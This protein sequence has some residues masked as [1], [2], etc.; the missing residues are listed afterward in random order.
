VTAEKW[1]SYPSYASQDYFRSSMEGHARVREVAKRSPTRWDLT[2][3]NDAVVRAFITDVY[4]FSV[5]DYALLRAAHP[6]VDIIVSASKW[7]HF[8]SEAVEA[9]EEDRVATVKLGG[10][11]MSVLHDFANGRATQG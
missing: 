6:E 1:D 2:L 9:A 8:S 7:N 11:L 10:E 3:T 4:T 5:A